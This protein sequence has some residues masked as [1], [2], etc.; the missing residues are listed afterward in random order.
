MAAR[1]TPPRGGGVC[2]D[3]IGRTLGALHAHG[4]A[5]LAA[6]RFGFHSAGCFFFEYTLGEQAFR[7]ARHPVV[8]Y[9][10]WTAL[11]GVLKKKDQGNHGP[12]RFFDSCWK[13]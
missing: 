12:S 10:W 11:R 1:L 5:C 2:H 7:I 9:D 3:G 8:G 13:P 6:G 4:L